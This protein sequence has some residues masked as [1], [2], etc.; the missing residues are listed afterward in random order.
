M[1]NLLEGVA[2]FFDDLSADVVSII[3]NTPINEDIDYEKLLEVAGLSDEEVTCFMEQ[4]LNVGLITTFIPGK[5]DIDQYREYV[6][7]WRCSHWI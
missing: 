7:K 6:Y 1:Y 2:H 5:N 4:L 3:L